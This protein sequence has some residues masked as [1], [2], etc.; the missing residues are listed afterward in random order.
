MTNNVPPQLAYSET[1]TFLPESHYKYVLEQVQ[2]QSDYWASRTSKKESLSKG[3][4]FT[5][6]AM[7]VQLSSML[8]DSCIPMDACSIA[9]PGAGTGI[10]SV[11]MASKIANSGRSPQLMI[12]GFET[13]TRLKDSWD[14]AW[15]L[16]EKRGLLSVNTELHT[17][18]TEDAENLLKT[19][20]IHG[21]TKPKIIHSN[22][23]YQK[24]G[25]STSLS[26]VLTANGVPVTNLYA[27]F[28]ALSVCWLE[29]GGELLAIV[30]RSFASGDYFKGFRA[31]LSQ[32]MSVEH[33]VLY[34]DRTNFQNVLQETILIRL[35]KK[36]TQTSDVRITVM[37]TPTSTP[38]YDLLMPAREI[39]MDSGWWMPRSKSDI[40]LVNINRN[41]KHTLESLGLTVSTG[42][43]EMHRLK[44]TI[45][46]TVLY[47]KDFDNDGNLSWAELKKP[48]KVNVEPKQVLELPKVGCYVVLKRISSNDGLKPQRLFPCLISRES[49]GLKSLALEN[50][51][52][53]LHNNGKPLTM[54][55]GEMLITS[56]QSQE[57]NAVIRSI[58]G[59]TQVNKSDLAQLRF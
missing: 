22:P 10:L 51:V 59:T 1:P 21:M 31:W 18:F 4:V 54:E 15:E 39:I 16:F 25:K 37:D 17:D 45:E 26:K 12:K 46:S 27:A 33:I 13:D 48:R 8:P 56:L 44:G 5:P 32:R 20:E 43:V 49:T 57:M 9:D 52:Q 58:G 42:K 2:G 6:L 34:R 40:R 24:L 55:Q 35:V 47:S 19:G 29:G 11:A 30:P 7:S 38:E 50:H 23:P 28:L 36:S 53:Y 3:Q 14:L 41:R